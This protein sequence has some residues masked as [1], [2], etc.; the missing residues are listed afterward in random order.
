MCL[1]GGGGGLLK[2]VLRC[3]NLTLGSTVV[4]YNTFRDL[5]DSSDAQGESVSFATSHE[6]CPSMLLNSNVSIP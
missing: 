4:H 5:S 3:N 1:G 2:P 6:A